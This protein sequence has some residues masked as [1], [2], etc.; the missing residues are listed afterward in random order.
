MRV[1]PRC[2]KGPQLVHDP[3]QHGQHAHHH[4][5]LQRHKEW[6]EHAHRN[7]LGIGRHV[8]LDGVRNKVDQAIGAGPDGQHSHRHGNAVDAIQQSV[9]QLHEV[10][11]KWLLRAGQLVIFG[12]FVGHGRKKNRASRPCGSRKNTSA[13][14]CHRAKRLR[15]LYPCQA[16][17]G[18]WPSAWA[19]SVPRAPLPIAH[20]CAHQR[21]PCTN[22]A[23]RRASGGSFSQGFDKQA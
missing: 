7:Q 5:H 21:A 23:P 10:L 18:A 22:G 2:H 15:C 20:A 14:F 13:A 11:H 16:P 1:Q 12:G 3:G 6:R 4:Q 8:R 17:Q 19:E 9:A